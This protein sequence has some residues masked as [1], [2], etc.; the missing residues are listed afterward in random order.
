MKFGDSVLIR[1]QGSYTTA[2]H[3]IRLVDTLI[4]WPILGPIYEF[5][6]AL[7]HQY[8]HIHCFYAINVGHKP[9][10]RLYLRLGAINNRIDIKYITFRLNNTTQYMG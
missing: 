8:S 10:D 3:I 5:I 9:I 1:C 4:Y 6:Y 2:L 7:K